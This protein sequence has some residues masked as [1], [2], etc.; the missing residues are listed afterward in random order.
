[1]RERKVEILEFLRA[2][3]A[4]ARQQPA[5]VP[6]QPRGGRVPVFGVAGHN[7]DVFTYHTLAQQLGPDQPFFGLRPP[8]L[9]SHSEPLDT[10]EG[11]AAYFADQILAVRPKGAVIV[12]GYCAGG[13]IAFELAQQLER[14]GT[15]VAFVAMFGCPYPTMFRFTTAKLLPGRV[16]GRAR[17]IAGLSSLAECRQYVAALCRPLR[18]ILTGVASPR[19]D[20]DEV[21]VM[22][23][24]LEQTTVAAVRRYVPVRFSGRVSLFLPNRRW[25]RSPAKPLRWQS[26]AQHSEVYYGPDDCAEHSM[27]RAPSAL[28]MADLFT[29]ARDRRG[30]PVA[31]KQ[32]A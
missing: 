16:A 2:A 8:G 12:A 18:N 23:T 27:L 14:R 9:D 24:R 11:L 25:L 20:V 32:G 21:S 30:T 26:L 17:A 15:P 28:A 3:E 1:M 22:R 13:T 19:A 7:G 31:L 10:V 5:I 4:A 6:L 29:L